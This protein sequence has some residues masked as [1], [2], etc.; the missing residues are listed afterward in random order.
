MDCKLPKLSYL[1]YLIRWLKLWELLILIDW[2]QTTY[3]QIFQLKITSYRGGALRV[4]INLSSI[5]LSLKF[6]V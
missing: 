3:V 1:R 4:Y 6:P 2:F 5:I